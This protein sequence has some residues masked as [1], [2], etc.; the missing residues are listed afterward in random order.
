MHTIF[1]REHNRI[2]RVL[3]T[4][5]PRW[6]DETVY[7]ETRRI[8]IAILQHISYWEWLPIIVGP[9]L[10]QKYQLNPVLN[11]YFSGYDRTKDARTANE[12]ILSY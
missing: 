10:M 4:L 5:N 8:V 6:D 12:V 9:R 7:Q 3:S 1:V 11:G 2:A